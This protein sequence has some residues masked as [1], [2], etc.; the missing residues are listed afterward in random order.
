MKKNIFWILVIMLSVLLFLLWER[1]NNKS[2][3]P[4]VAIVQVIE[5]PA[6]DQNYKGVIDQLKEE[7]LVDGKTMRLMHESAQGNP[8][9]ATQ[10][11]QKFVGLKADVI[12]AIGTTV[13]QAAAQASQQ[14]HDKAIPVVFTA[15]TDPVTAK[16]V[17]DLNKPGS[18]TTG[19]SDH[20]ALEKQL[21]FFQ[22]VMPNL[23][24]LGVIYNPGEANSVLLVKN[25][26]KLAPK[27]KLLLVLAT[28]SKTSEVVAAAQ[29]L[30]G[31]V[32][33]IF[34]NND[35]TALAAFDGI[36]KLGKDNK[37]PIFSSD[38]DCMGQGALAALGPD[39]YLLGKQTAK[40]VIKVLRKEK[41]PCDIP[42]EFPT[43][44]LEK[45][46]KELAKE[47]NAN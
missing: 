37:I 47:V 10:I 7:G 15:V 17:N 43:E 5:C 1:Y 39:Q 40:M 24:T 34:I 36:V 14:V 18:T 25:L 31:K 13:A 3:I 44:I 26:E 23:K 19:I 11:A 20:I 46:N 22:I 6:L 8:A 12:V 35:N 30:I 41:K 9:L 45:I 33:A 38:I 29:S 27:F 42:V 28:A 2:T 4:L 21:A 32:G 16:L